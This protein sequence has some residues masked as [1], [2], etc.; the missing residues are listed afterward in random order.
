MDI[1]SLRKEYRLKKLNRQSLDQSPFEQFNKWLLEAL[2][3][4]VMEP[5][6]MALATADQ[7]ARPSCRMVLMKHFDEKGLVFFTNLESQKADELRKNPHASA[8][9]WWKE[10]ERQVRIEGGIKSATEDEAR[11]Y[12]AKRP[13]KSQLGAWTSH[14]DAVVESRMILENEF[15]KMEDKFQG[16]EIPLPL[17]WGGFCII[18]EVFEFWQGREDRL[19]DRFR[20]RKMREEEGESWL[21]ERLSP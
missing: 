18:P 8:L 5:N 17:F 12:F 14:Q 2:Q 10:L 1:Q 20:Y 11:Q 9:F 7:A 4:D 13:R 3:V 15:K 21:I 6:A 19:H 16:Q